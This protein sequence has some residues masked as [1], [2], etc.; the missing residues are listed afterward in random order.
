MRFNSHQIVLGAL[1][2]A[3]ILFVA[4]FVGFIRAAKNFETVGFSSSE[5]DGVVVLTGG[6][7]RIAEGV[8]VLA[9]GRVK[10]LL[11]SGVNPDVTIAD[12]TRD[13]PKLRD[14]SECCVDLGYSAQNTLGNADEARVWAQQLNFQSLLIVT[15]SYHMPRAMAEM[16]H[17]LPGTQIVPHVVVREGQRGSAARIG[18]EDFRLYFLE[19]VKFLAAQGRFL[20]TPAPAKSSNGA[21]KAAFYG[22]V[23]RSERVFVRL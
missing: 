9:S 10:R 7:D 15:S 5:I 21:S 20:I 1:A 14:Y 16:Q 3:I 2:V 6:Q 12:L 4:G 19:Y 11:I 13:V 18:S 8:D 17:A 22:S 23:F